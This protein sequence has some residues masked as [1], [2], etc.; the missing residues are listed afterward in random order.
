MTRVYNNLTERT[1]T[2]FIGSFGP[3]ASMGLLG[4][5]VVD[6]ILLNII[7]SWP[8]AVIFTVVSVGALWL[9]KSDPNTDSFSTRLK[10]RIVFSFF[11][12]RRR[13]LYLPAANR[14]FQPPGMA[15]SLRLIDLVGVGDNA[16]AIANPAQKTLTAVFSINARGD[17]A[18]A[19]DTIN[20]YV[21]MWGVFLRDLGKTPGIAACQAVTETFPDPG[22]RAQVHIDKAVDPEAPELARELI[23]MAGEDLPDGRLAMRHR[24]AVVYDIAQRDWDDAAGEFAK[25]LRNL[26]PQLDAGGLSASLMNRQQVTEFCRR[27][28]S[29][30]DSMNLEQVRADPDERIDLDF[31]EVGPGWAEEQPGAF[32]HDQYVSRSYTAYKFPNDGFIEQVLRSLLQP[33]YDAPMKRVCV[34]YRPYS[35]ADA[36]DR[37]DS[38]YRDATRAARKTKRGQEDVGAAIR[39][40]GVD[41]SRMEINQNNGYG[42]TSVIVTITSPTDEID[43]RSQDV[44][45]DGLG[46]ASSLHMRSVPYHHSSHFAASL[47]IGV[48]LQRGGDGKL[49]HVI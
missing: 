8:V 7:R 13:N 16:V 29:P 44:L 31:S 35:E 22:I 38:D 42:R 28:Y 6:I 17:E 9:T 1:R 23:Q 18:L 34:V 19:D 15:A 24:L 3:L 25:Q 46:R 4:V 27:A 32:C 49:S 48:L 41:Q 12:A 2:G 39:L 21:D 47:G 37:V 11:K 14:T 36:F 40:R 30:T 45:V 10:D 5:M 33:N 20:H 43:E 26:K